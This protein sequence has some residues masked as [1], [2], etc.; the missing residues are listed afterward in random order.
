MKELY[1][2]QSEFIAGCYEKA[3]R[4]HKRI[5]GCASVGFGKTVV[6]ATLFQRS[7]AKGRT[8]MF[9]VPRNPLIEPTV[10]EFEGQGLWD[11]GVIQA[12]HPRTRDGA[13]LQVASIHT[14]VNRNLPRIHFMVVDEVHLET[15]KFNTLLDSPELANVVVIG[16][17]ATP[18]KKSMGLRWK[19][20]VQTKPTAQL[21]DEGFLVPARYIVGEEE[22][23]LSGVKF[24]IDSDGDKVLSETDESALMSDKR[25]V[26]DVAETW[27]K[28]GEGLPGFYYAVNLAHAEKIRQSFENA[29][30]S[31]AYIDGSMSRN[32]RLKIL[33]QYREGKFKIV[34]NYGVLTTGID[35]DVRCIGIC[36]IIRK[37]IDW[38]QII[39]RGL[40]RDNPTKRVAGMPEKTGLL[41]IDHGANLTRED[42]PMA[43]AEDIYHEYLDASDPSS[44]SPAFAEDEK[45]PTHRKCSQ[46]KFL[47]PPRVKICP[48]CG[49]DAP[50]KA[51]EV[52]VAVGDFREFDKAKAKA[53]KQEK[54]TFYSEA[55]GLAKERGYQ[56]G[57]AAH[58]YRDFYSVWPRCLL[59]RT[60][61]PS[62]MI[63]EF[64]HERRRA[65]HGN[66]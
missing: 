48:K 9:T 5:I 39:G 65:K 16:L 64:D 30:V 34:V 61:T 58:L 29:G 57:F 20:F 41:V 22:P 12:N 47:I 18:W 66:G 11:I 2:H 54:Q 51:K 35:E 33:R 42:S 60:A 4:G 6:A 38:V 15:Q 24:K 13:K 17:S 36:R 45:P 26:G 19:A 52:H 56:E 28:H 23:A 37:E 44:K 14:A 63:R 46:C 3:M 49:F 53:T 55:L 21:I 40:R 31:A 43:P 10:E 8:S 32:M 62:R 25:I 59:K 27:L 7:Y 50:V 1:D